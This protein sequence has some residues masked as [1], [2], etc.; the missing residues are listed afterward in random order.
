RGADRARLVCPRPPRW[1]RAGGRRHRHPRA[2]SAAPRGDVQCPHA[3][4]L[5]DPRRG[6]D[7]GRSRGAPPAR[8]GGSRRT[9]RRSLAQPHG[10]ARSGGGPTPGRR[11]ERRLWR[12][13]MAAALRPWPTCGGPRPPCSRTCRRVSMA[14]REPPLAR[15][16]IVDDDADARWMTE[17]ALRADYSVL[18]AASGSQGLARAQQLRPAVLVIDL[19]LGNDSGWNLIRAVQE[20]VRLGDVPIVVLTTARLTPPPGVRPCAAYL[21]KPCS[22]LRLRATLDRLVERASPAPEGARRPAS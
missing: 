21:T 14:T 20:D 19:T 7:A 5:P 18:T 22:L 12:P 17:Q 15:V 8:S 16:L 1:G 3:S 13:P 6:G 9:A 10:Q 11:G 4:G 2:G